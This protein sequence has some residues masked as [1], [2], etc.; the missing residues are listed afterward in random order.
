MNL[1]NTMKT[2][3]SEL[4]DWLRQIWKSFESYS[5][6]SERK[7]AQYQLLHPVPSYVTPL[8]DVLPRKMK[9]QEKL[10]YKTRI[11]TRVDQALQEVKGQVKVEF[12]YDGR[13]HF[14]KKV[15]EKL[16]EGDYSTEALVGYVGFTAQARTS[17]HVGNIGERAIPV[18][19]P[20]W[21][22]VANA[23]RAIAQSSLGITKLEYDMQELSSS[24][25]M[26]DVDLVDD[27]EIRELFNLD[28]SPT[29][30]EEHLRIRFRIRSDV[31]N[32]SQKVKETLLK[33]V[34]EAAQEAKQ[35]LDELVKS[36]PTGMSDESYE[37]NKEI[38][39]EQHQ[40]F[41]AIHRRLKD[42]AEEEARRFTAEEVICIFKSEE[43]SQSP[44]REVR[45]DLDDLED[46]VEKHLGGIALSYLGIEWPYAEQIVASQIANVKWQ[47]NPENGR[48][49]T[50]NYRLAWDD[51]EHLYEAPVYLGMY[52]P[53]EPGASLRAHIVLQT[54]KLLSG[55]QVH[56][57]NLDEDQSKVETEV[58][59]V[60]NVEIEQMD[61]Q[62][63]F[64]RRFF[65]PQ[66][67]LVF[68]GVLPSRDR[69][70]DAENILND[71]GLTIE[72]RSYKSLSE[73]NLEKGCWVQTRLQ[74]IGDPTRV[75][76]TV[77]G[78]IREGTHTVTYDRERQQIQSPITLGD[79][80]IGLYAQVV[81]EDKRINSLFDQ[82]QT[83]LE[84]RFAA[85]KAI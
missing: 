2:W 79:T 17:Y 81:S 12:P 13:K 37:K 63:I 53:T 4:V 11:G 65:Y 58:K 38:A 30:F 5:S 29:S 83:L 85:F 22:P 21:I 33:R 62:E 54:D 67:R 70:L 75:W 19:V 35:H 9:V 68:S 15:V 84:S 56:W 78:S 73:L 40:L 10:T 24:P 41:G 18:K 48:M 7:R 64:S 42:L 52:R 1:V 14:P 69:V 45:E 3:W 49:E 55:S 8:P 31:G 51:D 60:I 20:I 43:D 57:L 26:V 74:K 44:G 61:L 16:K 50:R 46:F 27:T 76:L 32:I 66:R 25:V 72:E 23:E 6:T 80:H 82:I 77:S 71:V 34:D 47:Y 36:K 28:D 59:S 39:A